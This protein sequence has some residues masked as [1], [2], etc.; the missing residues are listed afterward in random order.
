MKTDS[1]KDSKLRVADLLDCE[2]WEEY[3][4]EENLGERVAIEVTE[5]CNCSDLPSVKKPKKN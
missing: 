5:V 2:Q 4:R 1:I 3:R